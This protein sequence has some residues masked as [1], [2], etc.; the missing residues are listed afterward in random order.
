MKSFAI[1]R[2]YILI[3][4]HQTATRS[5]RRPPCSGCISLYSYIKPQPFSNITECPSAVYPYIP[6]SNRNSSIPF[7]LNVTAVYP[8]IPTSNRNLFRRPHPLLRCISLYSYIKPQPYCSAS[9]NPVRCISLYSYIK[10]Q[11]CF[12]ALL[13][14]SAVYPYIPTSNRNCI[15]DVHVGLAAVYPYIPTSNRNGRVVGKDT[16]HAVYPYIPTSNRNLS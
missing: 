13:F 14:L 7:D 5:R 8:Y 2:L 10:P 6:T 1:I 9:R 4:L 11:L 3:F 15:E 16:W 12:I